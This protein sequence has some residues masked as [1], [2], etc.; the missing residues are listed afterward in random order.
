MQPYEREVGD[1]GYL[2]L[3]PPTPEEL[4]EAAAAEEKRHHAE[5]ESQLALFGDWDPVHE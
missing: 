4:A 3:A 2:A 5:L 1:R